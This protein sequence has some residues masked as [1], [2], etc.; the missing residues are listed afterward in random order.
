[1]SATPAAEEI[2]VA[3]RSA[4]VEGRPLQVRVGGVDLVVLLVGEAV[5]VL[6]GRC[7]HRG[8]PMGEGRIEGGTLVCAAHG[9]DFSCA[10]GIS[11]QNPDDR[12]HKFASRVDLPG[13]AVLVPRREVARFLDEH[14]QAFAPHEHLGA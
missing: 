14:P 7:P 10:T 8:A 5:T 3:R 13:D 12:L 1:M 6:Y 9:W 11:P 4:L 2:V